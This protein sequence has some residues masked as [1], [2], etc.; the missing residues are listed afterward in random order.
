MNYETFIK[1]GQHFKTLLKLAKLTKEGSTSA[2]KD[3]E[4][5]LDRYIF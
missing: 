5:L 2:R 1:E 4:Y 3:L